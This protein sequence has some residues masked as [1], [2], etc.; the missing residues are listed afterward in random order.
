[1]RKTN[2]I[3]SDSLKYF[4][5][6]ILVLFS[7]FLIR[8][9]S[10]QADDVTTSVIIGNNAPLFTSDPIEDP[11]ETSSSPADIGDSVTF[12]ATGTDGNGEDYYLLVCSTDSATAVNNNIPYCNGGKTYCTST[13]T[14]SGSQ[15]T[16]TY[17]TVTSDPFSNTWYA[18]VCD[19]NSTE[20]LC[21]EGN[22]GTGD[23]G[24][25]FYVNHPPTFTDITNTSPANPGGTITWNATAS[26][27]DS[28][29]VKLLVCKT[30][31]ITN[32][33]CTNEAWCT[34]ILSPSN[35]S[36]TYNVPSVAPDGSSNAYAFIVDQYNKPYSQVGL[37]S[38]FTIN[39]VP[40]TV[41]A[42]ALNNNSAIV[43]SES[44][45]TSVSV[46]ATIT[47]NN[48]CSGTEIDSVKA[49]AYRSGIGNTNCS[50]L[51]GN[52]NNCYPEISCSLVTGS[53]TGTTDS[54]ANYTCS[55]D[56]Q[57]YA[58]PTDINTQFDAQNW[59]ATVKTTDDDSSNGSAEASSGVELNSLVAFNTGASISYGLLGVGEAND[60]LD[61]TL[62]TTA[63]GNVG[64]DQE[65]SGASK[66]CTDF[67][68]YP[69]CL[70]ATPIPV[71]YQRYALSAVAYSLGTEL[72][73]TPA[74]VELNVP[75]VTSST[76]TTGTV[77]WGISI[78]AGI[79]AG[80]YNGAN[81]ITAVKGEIA[82]W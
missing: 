15:A 72:T 45:T 82:N 32:G 28:N 24:S 16:C 68:N 76:P 71:E 4:L 7:L 63:T 66:M 20:A 22:Q 21:S 75:K 6:P 54:S 62:V 81:T 73:T 53:C 74:E 77:W 61:K 35:P 2:L 19:T 26:D 34:S 25:P 27:P 33:A 70:G 47:D 60:P 80:T 13:I 48:S 23:S 42:V 51:P 11:A 31:S 57:Y 14:V 37:N 44:T 43:L 18:F 67:E 49:Y 65:H 56:M 64:L 69:N 10:V 78:P 46:T 40:P 9:F 50:A 55:F 36:C 17:T 1:M 3:Q 41:S 52:N 30:D 79:I 38:Y 59:L 58:D 12:K 5:I 8:G 29:T 39:N